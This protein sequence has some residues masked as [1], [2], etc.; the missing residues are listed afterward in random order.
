MAIDAWLFEQ[1]QKGLHR[2]TLRFYTWSRPTISLGYLQ[3]K[4]PPNWTNLTYKGEAIA[5]VRR[6]TGGRAVLHQGDL[7]YAVV[8][9]KGTAKSWEIYQEI[10]EFLIQG[11]QNLGV[12]LNYGQAGRGYIRNPSCFNTAT[13]ADLITPDGSKFIG[14]AQRRSQHSILQH[15]STIL[16]SDRQ[17]FETIFQ[18]SAPWSKTYYTRQQ[19]RDRLPFI[20]ETLQ[21]AA[22][23]HLKIEL[24]PQPFTPQEWDSILQYCFV[25]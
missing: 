11:W 5:L 17:L 7:T 21:N 12:E 8:T 25:D 13:A 14:S 22:K 10:C 18:Q 3:K 15:G 24:D 9:E 2:S 1:H 6:P 16:Y 19:L 20:L 23:T 4:I